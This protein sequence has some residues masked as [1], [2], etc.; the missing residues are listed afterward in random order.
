MFV[1]LKRGEDYEGSHAYSISV[2]NGKEI[3]NGSRLEC[4][5]YCPEKIIDDHVL[6]RKSSIY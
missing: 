4:I 2:M 6:V 1:E 5:V 3:P